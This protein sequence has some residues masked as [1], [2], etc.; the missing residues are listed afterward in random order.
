VGSCVWTS[1]DPI[2]FDG[3]PNFYA[4]ADN[5]PTNAVDPTGRYTLLMLIC[6]VLDGSAQRHAR[7]NAN[8]VVP[9]HPPNTAPSSSG[10][11]NYWTQDSWGKGK[12]RS[13]NGAEAAYDEA[14]NLLPDESANYTFNYAPDPFTIQHIW[15]DVLPDWGLGH[16]YGYVPNLTTTY[17]WQQQQP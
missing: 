17:D 9:L 3:G 6:A 16:G 13:W 5:V 11:Q 2:G 4:Y 8:N 10:E 14:G 15:W 7:R 1:K 12:W